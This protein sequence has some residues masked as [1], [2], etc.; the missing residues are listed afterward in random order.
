MNKTLHDL[1]PKKSRIVEK[2][3]KRLRGNINNA[4][5]HNLYDTIKPR[6]VIIH[7]GKKFVYRP[8]PKQ[9]LIPFIRCVLPTVIARD[10]VG[11]QY[12]TADYN[13]QN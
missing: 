3:I 9:V 12:M 6:K 2:T 4:L 10:I 8:R 5:R 1:P 13:E 11:A 7:R